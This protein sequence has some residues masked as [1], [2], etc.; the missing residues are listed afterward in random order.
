MDSNDHGHRGAVADEAPLQVDHWIPIAV[1]APRLGVTPE[2]LVDW[3]ENG[4]VAWRLASQDDEETALVN[5][6]EARRCA[7]NL[8][9]GSGRVAPPA[10]EPRPELP[11]WIQQLAETWR[12]AARTEAEVDFLNDKLAEVTAELEEHRAHSR[13]AHD[14]L[15]AET[16]KA[17]AQAAHA[18][19]AAQQAASS[20]ALQ[21]E[22]KALQEE[23][24]E[25]AHQAAVDAREAA[26]HAATRL[27]EQ[28]KSQQAAER[29]RLEAMETVRAAA[30]SAQ[31]AQ[32]MVEAA[33]REAIEIGLKVREDMAQAA[34]DAILLARR[35]SED[36][37]ST[38]A[39][40]AQE[41]ARRAIA[42]AS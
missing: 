39:H 36:A 10:P 31:E 21:A 28:E 12:Q 18:T 14:A 5:F 41:E 42:I 1:A 34:D 30:R 22:T 32:A 29:A 24:V 25:A 38:A 17:V 37:R 40:A 19:L 35:A 2:T 6:E 11:Q 23:L 13:S 27:A 8:G 9:G 33:K 4:L 15:V 7:A 16:R 3:C 20:V 26:A